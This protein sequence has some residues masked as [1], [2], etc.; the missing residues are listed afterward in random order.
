MTMSEH[1]SSSSKK[2]LLVLP[3][4]FDC[5]G[6]IQMF[7]R[8]FCLAAGDWAKSTGASVSAIVLN[9]TVVPDPRY[10]NGSFASYTGAGKS[11]TKF[12]R[13]Y[14]RHITSTRYDWII[15]GHVSL[16]PLALL[17]RL[18]NPQVKTAIAAYGIE[19]FERLGKLE[20]RALRQTD[21]VLAI[22]E[23]TKAEVEKHGGIS[24]DKI[25][26]FPCALD[27]HWEIVPY[28]ETP[29]RTPPVILSVARMNKADRYKGLDNVI[30]SLPTVVRKAGAVEYRIVGTGDD[31]TYL[32]EL[33][34]ELGVASYVNFLGSMEDAE[35]REQYKRCSL[36]VMP[37]NNEGFGIVFLE[38]MA[39]GKPVV[40]GAHGGTP[41]VIKDGETGLLVNH[42]DVAG[43]AER[44]TRLISNNELSQS[45]G[46]AGRERLL[47]KFTFKQFERNLNDVL[48]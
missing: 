32:R 30:R 13:R 5:A 34:S 39:Y 26:L 20:R 45:L 46:R 31:V 29:Q 27:P 8:A 6:G 7:C 3:E 37:S 22:S 1:P 18:S 41:T 47:A 40:G 10:V 28:A 38:A 23:Y 17:A 24:A 19:V 4:A 42:D 43:I 44:I 9:D 25:R 16:S 35:L 2:L 11:K 12:V 33:A 48:S 15:F 14:L 21:V 36:F